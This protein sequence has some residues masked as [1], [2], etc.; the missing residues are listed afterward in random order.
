MA[1]HLW[2]AICYKGVS[3]V[4]GIVGLS[5]IVGFALSFFHQRLRRFRMLF[6]LVF[7]SLALGPGLVVNAIL[8]DNWGRPRPRD[9]VQYGGEYEFQAP[10]VLSDNG[11]KSFPCG[12]CSVPFALSCVAWTIG[13]SRRGLRFLLLVG[14]ALVGIIVGLAR[15][16]VGAHY[17]SDVVVSGAISMAIPWALIQL[18]PSLSK[19]P[20]VVVDSSSRI[21]KGSKAL[22]ITLAVVAS[23]TALTLIL[24]AWPYESRDP[25][26]VELSATEIAEEGVLEVRF[27]P[28]LKGEIE[29]IPLTHEAFLDFEAHSKGFGFPWSDVEF[30]YVLKVDGAQRVLSFKRTKTGFF[31]ELHSE[32]RLLNED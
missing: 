5:V 14:F 13:S 25:L 12:H 10:W 21:R 31:T 3:L 23:V 26:K 4:T 6:V 7:L 19:I 32:I 1:D 15:V 24:A 27:E 18:W 9:T 29:Q 16:A 2:V 30:S 17:F 22:I 28:P 8:K 20:E 11:G